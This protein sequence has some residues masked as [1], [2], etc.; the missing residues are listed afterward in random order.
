MIGQGHIL[1]GVFSSQIQHQ[2]S[3]RVGTTATIVAE[4]VK[5][6]VLQ[7]MLILSKRGQQIGERFHR[8]FEFP[9]RF[10]EC[11]K[12]RMPSLTAITSF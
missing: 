12:H 2:S 11:D 9:N 7:Q 6:F 10:R 5:G 1:F 4:L 8:N 3:N